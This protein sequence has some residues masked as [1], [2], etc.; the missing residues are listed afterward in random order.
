MFRFYCHCV[1]WPP[2]D[3]RGG[4]IPM[5][6]EAAEITRRTFLKHVH[7]GD[8]ALIAK[9]LG[10]EDHP[11]QGLTMAGDAY[12]SYHRSKL[13]GKRVYYFAWSGI[14]Y[15]FTQEATL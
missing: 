10:Y 2:G 1:G 15:V 5:I 6:D 3:V 13:H 11:T 9:A 7:R 12:I 14:E 4:L 8:L